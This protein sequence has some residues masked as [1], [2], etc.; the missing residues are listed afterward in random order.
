MNFDEFRADYVKENRILKIILGASLVIFS[1]AT[2]I[3][4]SSTRYYLYKGKE[5]FQERLLSEDVCQLGFST[6]VEGNPNPFVV[7][8]GMMDLVKRDP[9]LI[10]VTK[11]LQVKSLET[12]ACKIILKAD[13]KLLAFKVLM[14][15]SDE[16][17]FYYKISE[18]NEL[19][20]EKGD[21]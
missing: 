2:M 14:E 12:G 18:I 15:G 3:S 10:S 19:A 21:E 1:V 5:I 11:Y 6:L 4:F 9:F 17:P 13:G 8:K 7:S 16:H 20:V